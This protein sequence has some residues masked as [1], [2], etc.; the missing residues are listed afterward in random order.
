MKR[1]KVIFEIYEDSL[2]EET[3]DDG[4]ETLEEK[5]NQELGWLRDSGIVAS[6]WSFIEEECT[7]E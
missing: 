7:A 5:I 6:E 1:I 3:K 4:T 2:S